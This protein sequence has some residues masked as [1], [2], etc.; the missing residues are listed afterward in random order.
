M[1]PT[2]SLLFWC[3][4]LD[5]HSKEPGDLLPRFF[6]C[7]AVKI[8][9]FGLFGQTLDFSDREHLARFLR[10]FGSDRVRLA[11]NK[12]L[13]FVSIEPDE[14]AVLADVDSDFSLVR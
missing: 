11:R 13:D 8:G 1:L 4:E 7:D 14:M 2:F 6:G 10:E 9:A 12:P 3:I 5:W